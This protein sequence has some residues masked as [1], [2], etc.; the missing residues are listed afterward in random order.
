MS[1]RELSRRTFAAASGTA[2]IAALAGCTGDTDSSTNSSSGSNATDTTT[3]TDSAQDTTTESTTTESSSTE[4]ESTESESAESESSETT[5]DESSGDAAYQMV[6]EYEGQ[7]AGSISTGDSSRSVEGEGS[8]TIDI[9]GDTSMLGVNAQKQEDNDEKLV[10]QI[11]KNGEVVK[12]ASTSAAFGVAQTSTNSFEEATGGDG[13]ESKESPFSYHVEYEGEWSG[14]ITAGGSSRTVEGD[15]SKTFDIQ[16]TPDIISVNAQKQD[17]NNDTLTVQI[18][19]D[20]DVVKEGS[21][22]AGFGVAS[23][24]YSNF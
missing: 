4:S 21:T 8:K 1:D 16:G 3:V 15:G 5:S 14:T 19:K 2:L 20:G 6:V 22:S 17:D 12:E 13:S 7:W 18:L 9:S 24:T 10:V 11:L 23:I